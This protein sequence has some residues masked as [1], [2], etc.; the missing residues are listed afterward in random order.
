MK[1]RFPIP[2]EIDKEM[3]TWK[4]RADKE[5]C[6]DME[7]YPSRRVRTKTVNYNEY[8]G[9]TDYDFS[10][11]FKFDEKG[12]LLLLLDDSYGLKDGTL[13]VITFQIRPFL[14]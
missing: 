11:Y 2:P 6:E 7:N 8:V 13:P 4:G 1:P 9:S 12:D 3:K 5:T 10:I 14:P